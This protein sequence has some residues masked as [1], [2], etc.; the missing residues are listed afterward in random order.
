MD[1]AH[2]TMLLGS[3]QLGVD[4]NVSAFVC[5]QPRY[6]CSLSVRGALRLGSFEHAIDFAIATLE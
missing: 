4:G 1:R 3:D 6:L 2:L 5:S